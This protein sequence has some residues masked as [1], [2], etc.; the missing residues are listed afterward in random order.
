VILKISEIHLSGHYL[1]DEMEGQMEDSEDDMTDDG[2]DVMEAAMGASDDEDMSDVSGDDEDFEEID[3][4][5]ERE[6]MAMIQYVF[7]VDCSVDFKEA[8]CA[9]EARKAASRQ[10]R[11]KAKAGKA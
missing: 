8:N 11:A 10:G 6:V 2:E 9:K 3:S 7:F 1:L 4:E 5:T